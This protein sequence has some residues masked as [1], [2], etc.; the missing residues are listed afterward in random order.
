MRYYLSEYVLFKLGETSVTPGMILGFLIGFLIFV[1]L[2]GW[3]KRILVKRIFARTNFGAGT[4]Q[5]VGALVQYSIIFIGLLFCLQFVGVELTSL[6][7]LAGA[8]GVG[9]GFGL[10]NVASNFISGLIIVFEQPFTVGDRIEIGAITGKVAEIG[11]RSTKLLNDDETVS[12]VPN[13]KLIS[14]PVRVFRRF[15]DRIPQEIKFSAAAGSDARL[16]LKI[17]EQT[18]ANHPQ[19]LKDP[20]SEARFKSFDAGKLDFVLNVWR[21]T[22][23]TDLD[24]FLSDIN[25]CV[26]EE[27]IKS[28]IATGAPIEAD[29][30]TEKISTE[31]AVI[32]PDGTGD[33]A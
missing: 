21:E 17:L 14:E 25:V 26:Y 1:V 16:V 5:F 32:N 10:Q 13:Q 20:K 6:S 29:A 2:A 3:L 28:G 19:I 33:A 22:S 4:S 24:R 12:I 15:S 11:G 30:N 18:A 7:V 31:K 8:I 23:L 9:V 27:F